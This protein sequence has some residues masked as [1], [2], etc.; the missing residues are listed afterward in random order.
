MPVTVV[1]QIVCFANKKLEIPKMLYASTRT[2]HIFA[3]LKKV[4]H[5]LLS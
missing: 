2:K 1:E 3:I 5:F 4:I